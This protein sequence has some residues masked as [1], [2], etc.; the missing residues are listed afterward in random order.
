MLGDILSG[1]GSTL[2]AIGDMAIGASNLNYNKNQNDSQKNWAFADSRAAQ[3]LLNYYIK[4][5]SLDGYTPGLNQDYDD[6]ANYFTPFLSLQSLDLQKNSQKLSED[7][8]RYSKYVTENSAQIKAKDYEK[9]GF[10]PLLAVGGSASY[11]P[12]SVASGGSNPYS[13]NRPN[14]QHLSTNMSISK[15]I[16]DLSLTQA[17][18]KN[19][20]ADTALKN[21]QAV[22]ESYRPDEITAGIRKTNADIKQINNNADLLAEKLKTQGYT[23]ML[24][25]N[26]IEYVAQQIATLSWDYEMSVNYGTKSFEQLPLMLK[27]VQQVV[28]AVGVDVNS[29]MG[30]KLSTFLFIGLALAGAKVNSGKPK[31]KNTHTYENRDGKI[32]ERITKESYE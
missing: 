19:I 26:Q 25:Q 9:A 1:F 6:V 8:F 22:T 18:I 16:N 13:S 28:N 31:T 23:T 30:Q 5:G 11:S 24:T 7:Q 29:E 10:S 27:E 15:M 17:Q 4:N 14:L 32:T 21:N 3:H 12:V 20:N 2:G